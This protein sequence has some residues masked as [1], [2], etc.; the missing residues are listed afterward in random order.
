MFTW[1]AKPDIIFFTLAGV[2]CI[3]IS[4][5][6][7]LVFIPLGSSFDFVALSMYQLV[8]MKLHEIELPTK[9][10][11]AS[12]RFYQDLLGLPMRVGQPGL[13]VFDSGIGG[14]D[15]NTSVHNPGR[16]RIAFLVSDLEKT[17]G[18]LRA[19]GLKVSEPFDSHLGMRGVRLED[20]DGNL[21]VIQTP[22]EHSPDWLK[23]QAK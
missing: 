19:R 3:F 15:F 9:D 16:V 18:L 22:T 12:R 4:C 17:I 10:A 8:N 21:V 14:L 1:E 13:N 5:Q 11:E 20:P 7:G 6:H 2:D 23:H